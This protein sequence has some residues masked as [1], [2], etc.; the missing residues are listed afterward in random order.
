MYTLPQVKYASATLMTHTA[1]SGLGQPL[2]GEA[3]FRVTVGDSGGAQSLQGRVPH[4]QEEPS[5]RWLP[6]AL[7]G[8]RVL[9]KSMNLSV[10]WGW[11]Y[12]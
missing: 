1:D 4:S 6:D 12:L 5:G 11:G 2:Q 7:A 10:G 3:A 9:A 8:T